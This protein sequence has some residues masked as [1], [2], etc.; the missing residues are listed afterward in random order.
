MLSSITE[1][2]NRIGSV[3]QEVDKTNAGVK[4]KQEVV[5]LT[6]ELQTKEKQE[7]AKLQEERDQQIQ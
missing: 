3:A 5:Q 2:M 4:G 7:Q 6:Q 1:W